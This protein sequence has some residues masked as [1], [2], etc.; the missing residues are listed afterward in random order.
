[1]NTKLTLSIDVDAIATAK[2]YSKKKG[3]SLSRLVEDY[4]NSFSESSKQKRKKSRVDNLV[5][6]L[7]AAPKNFNY[8]K[9]LLA[10]LEEKHKA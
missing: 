6:I 8:K 4:F 5:G 3:L 2:K 10:I 9:E 7:D 1:M